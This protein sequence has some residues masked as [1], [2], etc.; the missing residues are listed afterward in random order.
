MKI[1]LS[2]LLIGAKQSETKMEHGSTKMNVQSILQQA[3]KGNRELKTAQLTIKQKLEAQK[4][5]EAKYDF[6]LSSDLNAVEMTATPVEGSFMTVTEQ[7]EL[8]L[9]AGISKLIKTGGI[10]SLQLSSKKIDQTM[11][12]NTGQTGPMNISTTTFQNKLNLVISHPLLKGFGVDVNQ[13]EI[14]KARLSKE[15]E[16]INRRVKAQ[17]IIRDVLISAIDLDF[18]YHQYKLLQG[19]LKI[20]E[21]QLK[22]T[23]LLLENGMAKQSDYLAVKANVAQR[24]VDLIKIQSGL[25]ASSLKL[26]ISLGMDLKEKPY[27]VKP[28]IDLD[29]DRYKKP[30]NFLQK[31]VARSLQLKIMSKEIKKINQDLKVANNQ[32]LPSLDLSLTAGPSGNSTEFG[33]SLK[34]MVS[35]D[36]FTIT[37][38]ISFKY[39]IGQTGANAAL[40]T[41]EY[42]R[43]SLEITKDDLA[44]AI[45]MS[46]ILAKDSWQSARRRYEAAKISVLS[47]EEHL[48]NEE[49]LYKNGKG[50]YH[51]VMLR[52]QEL[53]VA[54]LSMME[55]KRDLTAAKIQIL[56][57][58]NKL[59]ET[60]NLQLPQ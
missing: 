6:Q 19:S 32:L 21:D 1:M 27:L 37:G 11:E 35:F 9:E 22:D 52:M 24:K 3:I 58:A 31:A 10:V 4:M 36:A 18:A 25:L 12:I 47:S 33:D 29:L 49:F 39:S 16:V 46:A 55:A 8:G 44:Q 59:L 45:V 17:G 48:K 5:A 34:R 50:T 57:L 40:Q 2:F 26:K 51:S 54:K 56:T 13:A 30:D 20:A 23:K 42:A 43:D 38:N 7:Q 60:F 14:K 28:V 41:L 15:V 53:D